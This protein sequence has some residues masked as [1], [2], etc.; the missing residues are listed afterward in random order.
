MLKK[1]LKKKIRQIQEDKTEASSTRQVNPQNNN[2][3]LAHVNPS[4]AP[5]TIEGWVAEKA[6]A[7]QISTPEV[8][9]V[10]ERQNVFD[11]IIENDACPKTWA[12]NDLRK[13]ISSTVAGKAIAHTQGT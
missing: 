2:T 6:K 1:H 8:P 10:I 11:R 9:I 12:E 7:V 13:L 5:Q 3:P 4:P